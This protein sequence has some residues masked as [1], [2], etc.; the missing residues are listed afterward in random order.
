MDDRPERRQAVIPS[1]LCDSC[2]H[3]RVIVSDR[4]SRFVMCELAKTDPR[5]RRYPALPVL[6]CAGYE[7]RDTTTGAD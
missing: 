4:G 7:R 5:F 3:A 2:R 6:A 1:G